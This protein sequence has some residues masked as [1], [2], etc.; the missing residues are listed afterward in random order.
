MVCA[1]SSRWSSG[2]LLRRPRWVVLVSLPLFAI[3]GI[4]QTIEN[5]FRSIESYNDLSNLRKDTDYGMALF[6]KHIFVILTFVLA[7][8]FAEGTLMREDLE[9]TV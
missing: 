9:G 8:V 2:S 7:R 3:T 4:Y 1:L 5:P 6:V